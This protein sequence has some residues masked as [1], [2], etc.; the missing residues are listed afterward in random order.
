LPSSNPPLICLLYHLVVWRTHS[1]SQTPL[2]FRWSLLSLFHIASF[3][4][5]VS[6]CSVEIDGN[7]CLVNLEDLCFVSFPVLVIVKWNR[8]Q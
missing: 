1:S 2:M 7:M 5:L 4:H 8:R 6:V 3:L